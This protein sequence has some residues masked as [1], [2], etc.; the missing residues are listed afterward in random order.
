[1]TLCRND[2]EAKINR[3]LSFAV[4]HC[5]RRDYLDFST[6]WNHPFSHKPVHLGWEFGLRRG[7]DLPGLEN[8][9]PPHRYENRHIQLREHLRPRFD[10]SQSVL[11]LDRN[12]IEVSIY[13]LSDLEACKKILPF[14]Q[15]GPH[16]VHRQQ[17][18]QQPPLDQRFARSS[19]DPDINIDALAQPLVSLSL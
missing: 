19:S 6:A 3:L 10:V 15:G 7:P 9:P 13:T 16:C 17:Q 18:Q 12:Q 11:R 5:D 2:W 8:I 14:C 4:Q 1:M